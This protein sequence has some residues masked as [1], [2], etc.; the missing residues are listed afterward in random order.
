M[1]NTALAQWRSGQRSVGVWLT[2]SD[3]HSA[4]L[5]G[6]MGY[7]W[8]CVD[9][10]HGMVDAAD[11]WKILAALSASPTTPI[12]RVAGNAPDQIGRALDSGAL[13]VIVPMVNT[14]DE[15]R[16]AAAACRYPPAGTRSC[17]PV[18]S[19][20]YSSADYMA[21]AN[22]QLA[23]IVMIETPDGLQN[24]EAIA[25]VPGVDAL[26]VGPVD[27]CF[28]LGLAP[29][30]FEAAAFRAAVR[31]ILS[32]GAAT[33]KPVGIFGYSAEIAAR[34]L[35]DGFVFAS[36]GTDAGFLRAAGEDALRR[37]RG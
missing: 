32:A 3:L 4:E 21:T 19:A 33:G 1:I 27:L 9:L 37:V 22:D 35:D 29:G 25:A 6:Q 24:V 11:L 36:A 13:G 10:Q 34:A 15:A 20:A 23:C 26:F 8:L 30:D 2:L 16:A 31:R 7:D 17:G 12:V 14:A 28:A 5:A 18:R